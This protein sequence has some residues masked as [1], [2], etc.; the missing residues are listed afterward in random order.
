M[1]IYIDMDGV[2]CDYETEFNAVRQLKPDLQFPQSEPGFFLRLLPI[3]GAI[4]AINRLSKEH[5]VWILTSPSVLNPHS[6]TEKR[7][8]VEQYFGIEICKKLILSLDKSLLKGDV[9]IDDRV[10]SNK[11]HEFEGYLLLFGGK[12]YPNWNTVER[13]IIEL[14]AVTS[15]VKCARCEKYTLPTINDNSPVYCYSCKL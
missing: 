2:I 10:D 12:K 3:E 1:R 8:W 9:L 15:Y 6:Y 4:D 5:D 13:K 7:L 11:Q 14:G